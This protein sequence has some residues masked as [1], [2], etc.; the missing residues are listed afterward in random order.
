MQNKNEAGKK[1]FFKP[2]KPFF[3]FMFFYFQKLT[4]F[5]LNQQQYNAPFF[6]GNMLPKSDAHAHLKQRKKP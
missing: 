3:F 6:S 5:F 4:V 1:C 2:S